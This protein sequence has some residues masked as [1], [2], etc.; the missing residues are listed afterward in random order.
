MF[1]LG[2]AVLAAVNRFLKRLSESHWILLAVGVYVLLSQIVSGQETKPAITSVASFWAASPSEKENGL[3]YRY[4]FDVLFYDPE[5]RILQVSDGD[6]VEYINTEGRLP[7]QAGERIVV[8]GITQPPGDQFWIRDAKIEVV[9]TSQYRVRRVNLA[10]IDHRHRIN[11]AVEFAG[12]VFG[13]S[14]DGDTHMRLDIAS[15]GY[16]VS[17]WILVDPKAPV[18]EWTDCV[19]T[20]RGVYAPKFR[21]DGTLRHIEIFCPGVDEVTFVSHVNQAEEFDLA[22]S[23]VENLVSLGGRSRVR[24]VGKVVGGV[25]GQSLFVRDETGQV[26]VAIAQKGDWVEGA[27]VEVIGVPEVDG[28]QRHLKRAWVR[29]AADELTGESTDAPDKLLHRVTASVLELSPE[30]AARGDAVRIEGV[31][32]WSNPHSMDLF[33]QDSTGGIRVKRLG[34]PVAPPLPGQSV[35]INGFTA[36]GNFAPVVEAEKVRTIGQAFALPQPKEITLDQALTGV[37]EAQWVSMMGFVYAVRR[38]AGWARVELSTTTGTLTARLPGDVDVSDLVGEVVELNGVMSAVASPDRK[39]S[40]VE[41]RVAS[42]EFVMLQ[43]RQR[44]DTF[45]LPVSELSDVGLFS[46]LSN[47]YRQIKLRGTVLHWSPQ[48]WLWLENGTESIR[49]QTR[50]DDQ[51]VRGDEIEVVGFYGRDGGRAVLREGQY[52]KVGTGEL[53]TPLE[54]DPTQTVQTELDGHLV[55]VDGEVIE[56]FRLGERVRAAVQIDRA[57]FE[58]RLEEDW[59]GSRMMLPAKGSLVRINGLYLV[60]YNDQSEPIGFH[61]IVAESDQLMVLKPPQWWTPRKVLAVVL[62]LVTLVLVVLW[63]VRMLQR[64]VALQTRQ[65]E[66]QMRRTTQL[67][68]DLNRAARLESLGTLAGGI[69]QDFSTLLSSVHERI[70]GAAKEAG[71]PVAAKNRL[72]DARAASLRARDLAH[73]LSSFSDGTNPDLAHFDVG[74]LL[75]DEVTRFDLPHVIAARWQKPAHLPKVWSDLNMVRQVTQNLLFNAVQAMPR[76]GELGIVFGVDTFGQETDALLAPGEYVRVELRDA[77]EGISTKNI[78]RVFDPYFTTRPGAQGLGLSVVYSLL[79]RL[80]GRVVVE[81]TPMVGTK[82]TFWLP[83]TKPV[84]AEESEPLKI[85]AEPA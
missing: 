10:E 49:V 70:A 56:G 42:R 26:T 33:V 21:P 25:E 65:I 23:K 29:K 41:L 7:I 3:I 24:V 52:R 31:V 34:P 5:W 15:E 20:V 53:S 28:I 46:P 72:E 80:K 59:R 85:A 76:G 55:T 79:R 74:E 77:G 6:M 44:L 54:V 63:W 27:T 58:L 14:F 78:G 64:R 22:E 19:V 32:T 37:E 68:A 75:E 1:L 81:S 9:G 11:E 71:L 36:K 12:L 62:G 45:D 57:V 38:D 47:L 13:Q 2:D 51:L 50:Q 48:E 17:V 67:E 69:A 39:L 66:E 30:Q 83:V 73:Q 84:A 60:D 40:D 16:P 61:I 82:V 8:S 18:P 35:I 43:D 4:E